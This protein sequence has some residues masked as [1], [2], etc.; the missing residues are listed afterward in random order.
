MAQL[1][2]RLI[3]NQQIVSSNLTGGSIISRVYVQ[4]QHINPC[5]VLGPRR[6][7]RQKIA[8]IFFIFSIL[9]KFLI[10]PIYTLCVAAAFAGSPAPKTSASLLS[11]IPHRIATPWRK[12]S[13]KPSIHK[14]LR[15]LRLYPISTPH[16]F[17]LFGRCLNPKAAQ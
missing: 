14:G 16:F 11:L 3:R 6:N 1:V 7:F 13:R 10:Y 12:I 15:V 17:S 9:Q 8:K 4:K 2:E 5:F